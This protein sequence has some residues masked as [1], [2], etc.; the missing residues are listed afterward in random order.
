MAEGQ[1]A[2]DTMRN[3]HR[4]LLALA[5]CLPATTAMAHPHNWIDL[6]T[7]L[8]FDAEERLAAV[9]LDWLFD[10]F[11]TA[12]IAEEFVASGTAP[13]DFLREVAAENLA[14][15]RPY[16][17]FLDVRQD[18]ERLKLGDVTRFE[19]SLRGE[20]LAL[21]FTIPLAEP[22]APGAE[23][24]TLAVYDPTYYIEVLYA[25]GTG[26]VLDGIPEDRCSTFVMPPTPD[27]EMVSLAYALDMT[28]SA[29]DGL[30]VHFA[31]VATVQC[32]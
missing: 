26:P 25:E 9:E 2:G 1:P 24:I 23:G 4:T 27:P 17:Y 8:Q 29:G 18:G 20:R 12:F 13:S 10:E 32:P 15:L 28:Q 31:E 22:V 6:G 14:N 5:C 11:Y 3:L 30:G 7:R 21:T 19:T 16:D